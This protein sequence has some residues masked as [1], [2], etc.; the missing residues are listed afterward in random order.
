[1]AFVKLVFSFNFLN[2]QNNNDNEPV[3][4]IIINQLNNGVSLTFFHSDTNLWVEL[5]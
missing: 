3:A 2:P 5:E 1:M 4:F